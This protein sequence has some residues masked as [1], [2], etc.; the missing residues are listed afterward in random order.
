MEVFEDSPA[1][2]SLTTCA[3]QASLGNDPFSIWPPAC[4]RA[5]ILRYFNPLAARGQCETFMV[6]GHRLPTREQD[7]M[8]AQN[9][10]W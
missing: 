3:Y 1:Q 8:S 5:I 2:P 7:V 6:T 9:K 4:L 10:I